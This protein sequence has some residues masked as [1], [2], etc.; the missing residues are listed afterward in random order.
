MRKGMTA[1][2]VAPV[3]GHHQYPR[4]TYDGEA[5]VAAGDRA[6]DRAWSGARPAIACDIHPVNNPRVMQY[7]EREFNVPQVE[8]E[9]WSRHWIEEG[10]RARIPARD[11][12][13]SGGS[14]EGDA[15]D[16]RCLACRGLERPALGVDLAHFRPSRASTPRCLAR[17]A[18]SGRTKTSRTPPGPRLGSRAGVV[19]SLRRR[20]HRGR[21]GADRAIS[22][23][24][25]C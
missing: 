7:L 23:T 22:R 9:R 6:R 4:W 11:N 21:P 5:T 2:A 8:R 25:P 12:P 24:R 19:K 17:P 15:T 16:D 18:S 3:H 20:R 14:R 13:S 1:N 10:F